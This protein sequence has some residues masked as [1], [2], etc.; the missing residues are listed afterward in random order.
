M[1]TRMHSADELFRQALKND[2]QAGQPNSAIEERLGYQFMLK[3]SSRK[4]Y[5]NSFN[6]SFLSFKAF[7]LKASLVTACLVG[8]LFFVKVNNNQ[9]I[10]VALDSCQVNHALADSNF[11][12][13]DTC[14]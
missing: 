13:K 5:S 12:A 7:G 4:L 10:S 2:R 3:H 8:I 11:V 14:R 6:L 9:N 1:K